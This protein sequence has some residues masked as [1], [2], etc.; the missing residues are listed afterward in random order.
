[1]PEQYDV[2][3]VGARCAGSPLATWLARRGLKVCVLDRAHFPSETPSTHIVQPSVVKILDSLGVLDNL[4]AA[5]AIPIEKFRLVNEDTVLGIDNSSAIF[6]APGLCARRVTLDALLVDA[7]KAAG[8]TVRTGTKVRELMTESGRVCGVVTDAGTIRAPLVVGAD[9][10]H[11][12]V[13]ESVGAREYRISPA[14]RFFVWGYYDGVEDHDCQLSLTRTGRLAFI[15]GPTDSG[16][17]MAAVSVEVGEADRF[18]ADR[19]ANYAK[20]MQACPELAERL[21]TGRRDG[22]LRIVSNWHGYFREAAG[23]GWALLGDAGHFKDPTPGQG[24]VDSIR[25]GLKLADAIEAGLSGGSLDT[26][27]RDWWRWRDADGRQMHW[28][29]ADLGAAGSA[30]PVVSQVLRDLAATPDSTIELFQVINRDLDPSAVFTNRRI[31]GAVGRVIR[32]RLREVPAMTR[33]VAAMARVESY[34]RR[35][36]TDRPPIAIQ[37]TYFRPT[38]IRT[39]I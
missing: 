4:W 27:L 11:S 5:G 23:P 38:A 33:E 34:R 39:E 31:A 14:E 15:S 19:D 21:S 22:P 25:H 35:R 17:Y 29:A 16:I 24:I 37:T 28:F 8:A 7:A 2:V 6:G 10:R 1:M 32:H 30:P 9:G 20:A 36:S 12:R 18:L 26:K 13:A 3:I